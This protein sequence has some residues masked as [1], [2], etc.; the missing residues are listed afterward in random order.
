MIQLL[1]TMGTVTH[2]GVQS[3]C[4]LLFWNLAS[5]FTKIR[6]TTSGSCSAASGG[7]VCM[8]AKVPSLGKAGMLLNPEYHLSWEPLMS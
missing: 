3:L 8:P 1:V 4:S 2:A 5:D 7:Y 6:I